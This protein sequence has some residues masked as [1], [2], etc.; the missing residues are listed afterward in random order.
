M[1]K[2]RGLYAS[3]MAILV[4]STYRS[5]ET[6]P[7]SD[8]PWLRIQRLHGMCG[9]CVQWHLRRSQGDDSTALLVF[10]ELS[11]GFLK[12]IFTVP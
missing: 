11:K 9:T 8:L 2:S 5:N 6:T 1:E 3:G 10:L 12:C 7:L 4:T